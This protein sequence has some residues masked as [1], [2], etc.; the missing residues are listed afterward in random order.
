MSKKMSLR[1]AGV[2]VGLTAAL[3]PAAL[4]AYDVNS[5]SVAGVIAQATAT[6]APKTTASPAAPKTGNAGLQNAAGGVVAQAT[7]TAAPKTTAS[8]AAPKTG[9]AGLLNAAGG[10][11]AQATATAAPKTTASP[12][13]P[14]TGNAGFASEAGTAGVA[15]TL[16]V[17]AIGVVAGG[18]VLASRRG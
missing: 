12:A 14:K 15:A 4:M 2:L 13:A 8:P 16:A 9:N 7:A 11:V 18:R 1:A 5:T 6:A 3:T 17:L 10:V